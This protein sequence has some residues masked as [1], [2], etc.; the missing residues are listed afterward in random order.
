M[1]RGLDAPQASITRSKS[2]K[3]SFALWFFPTSAPV[4]KEIPSSFI[5]STL[6]SITHFSSFIL[7]IPYISRPPTRSSRSNTV[8][9]WPRLFNWSAAAKPAGPEPMTATRFPVLIFGGF[10]PAIPVSYARRIM[11]PSFSLMATGVPFNPQVQA[12]SHGAGH[13]REVNSGKLLVFFKRL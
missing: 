4:T 1:S 10:G 9:L 5:T 6:R 7:G 11:A 3:M 12:A 2:F 8:T 13:T